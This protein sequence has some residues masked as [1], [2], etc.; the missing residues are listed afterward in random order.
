LNGND[1]NSGTLPSSAWQTISKVVSE[2]SCFAAG[3][4]VYFL[5]G[6]TWNDELTLNNVHGAAG[7]P[8]TFSS[9]AV[10]SNGTITTATSNLQCSGAGTPYACCTGKGAGTCS[11]IIDGNN[12][13]VA[14][15]IAADQ[16]TGTGSNV[17]YITINGFECRNTSQYGIDFRVET[18]AMPGIIIQNNYIHN[19][20]PGADTGGN[21]FDDGNYRNQLNAEDDTSGASGGDGFQIIGNTVKNCGGHNCLQ[22]HYDTGGPLVKGNIVGPGCVHNCID[23]KGVVNGQVSN[24]VVTCPTCSTGTAAFYT[25]NTYVP[26][27]TITYTGNIAYSAPIAFQAEAGGSCSHSPC[28]I[29][30]KYYN[31]TIYVPGQFNFIDSSCTNHILDIE[32]NIVGGATTDIHSN[33]TLTWNY[34]DDGD[35]GLSATITGNPAGFNDLRDVPPCYASVSP[36]TGFLSPQSTSVCGASN[37]SSYLG[38]TACT[39]PTICQ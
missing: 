39:T 37:A 5:G 25:E 36:G 26:G 21:G 19:T 18:I 33:C 8:I 15:C 20:G 17:S 23:T 32:N 1:S 11:A 7:S 27:E 16:S 6:G 13:A 10:N 2:E 4:N 31:N 24:N 35:G 34:N 12:G 30:A 28:S 14:S 29:N 9:Y 3:V 38:A 22:V